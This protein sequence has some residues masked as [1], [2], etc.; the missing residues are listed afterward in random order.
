[1]RSLISIKKQTSK[2]S[3]IKMLILKD[4]PKICQQKF[5]SCIF[6]MSELLPKHVRYMILSFMMVIWLTHKSASLIVLYKP[7]SH[8]HMIIPFKCT[9]VD[10]FEITRTFQCSQNCIYFLLDSLVTVQQTFCIFE[11]LAR[12]AET[13]T[14]SMPKMCLH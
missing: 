10:I 2:A 6:F 3:I 14:I 12:S 1:M 13:M 5:P 8:G 4:Y 7:N 11:A 9:Y